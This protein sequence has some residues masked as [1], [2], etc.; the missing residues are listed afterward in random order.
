MIALAAFYDLAMFNRPGAVLQTP[1]SLIH[2]VSH[3]FQK[4]PVSQSLTQ[5]VTDSSFSSKSSKHFHS[6]TVRA[7]ELNFLENVQH[8]STPHMSH[9]K[10]HTTCVR[11]PVSRVT[12]EGQQ[13]TVKGWCTNFFFFLNFAVSH[14]LLLCETYFPERIKNGVECQ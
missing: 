6:Q 7:R 14:L 3:Y 4:E 10:Y 2:S 13:Q 5:S 11:Y 9:V 1:L 8:P 12:C